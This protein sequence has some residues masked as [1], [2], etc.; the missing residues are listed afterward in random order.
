MASSCH[1]ACAAGGL[2]PYT[3]DQ[4]QPADTSARKSQTTSPPPSRCGPYTMRCLSICGSLCC[5]ARSPGCGSPRPQPFG[6]P[7][8]ISSVAWFTRNSKG[9]TSRSRRTAARSPS[10]SRKTWR[11][12]CR[13]R[14][15]H[16]DSA[17]A[18]AARD[19]PHHARHL[20]A[21]VARRGR[22]DAHRDQ[23]CDRQAHEICCVPAA[24]RGL[25]LA[26]APQVSGVSSLTRRSRAQTRTGSAGGCTAQARS[27]AC[28]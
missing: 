11:C 22:V 25:V 15:S 8:L 18:D 5:W 26:S 24:Y 2:S 12:C 13:R 4:P 14:C 23:C 7:T 6:W 20:W 27:R 3:F 10:R 19:R 16:Q 28:S 9:P 17:G 1:R 21:S